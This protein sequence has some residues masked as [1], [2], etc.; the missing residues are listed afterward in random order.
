[1]VRTWPGQESVISRLP[2][3]TPSFT[4]PSAS[5]IAGLTPKNGSV[6]EPGLVAI[7]PGSGEIMMPPVSVPPGVDD[8]AAFVADHAVIPLPRFRIDRFA[9]RAEQAQRGARGLLHRR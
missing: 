6:A 5:T 9:D 3:A 2:S 7:A 8:R 1:M 4:V